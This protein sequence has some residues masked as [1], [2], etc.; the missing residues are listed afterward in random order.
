MQPGAERLTFDEG[1]HIIEEAVGLAR[2]DQP[3]D[4]RMLQAGGGLDLAEEALAADDGRELGVED[5]DG[6]LA[7]VLQV[8]G[9]VDRGHAALAELALD[10]IAVAQGRRES[11]LGVRH[12]M[13]FLLGGIGMGRRS[14]A[15]DLL[16]VEPRLR[17]C[18]RRVSGAAPP[19]LAGAAESGSSW[20][21]IGGARRGVGL[22][23]P[24]FEA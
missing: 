17:W 20:S 13:L 11:G 18:D 8:L 19:A 23:P 1:H 9:E 2:I 10:A 4:V 21:W 3:Q 22:R 7:A 24:V 12:W 14:I 16:P 15:S 6:D 5:L